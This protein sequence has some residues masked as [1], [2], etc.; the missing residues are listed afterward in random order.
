M[1]G[2]LVPMKLLGAVIVYLFFAFLLGWGVLLAVRG[3]YWLLSIGFLAYL[4][5][6]VRIGCLPP[7]KLH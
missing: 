2:Y 3:S 6:M 5:A 1:N 4:V 7:G